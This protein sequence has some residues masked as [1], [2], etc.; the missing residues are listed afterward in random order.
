MNDQVVVVVLF[1][2]FFFYSSLIAILPH[3]LLI[4]ILASLNLSGVTHKTGS[5]PKLIFGLEFRRSFKPFSHAQFHGFPCKRLRNKK[6]KKKVNHLTPEND[7]HLMSSY[8]ITPESHTEVTRI[9][10]TIT[11]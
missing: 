11:N 8:N 2:A 5:A 9:N 6:R 7:E 3:F 10:K 4:C 1:S